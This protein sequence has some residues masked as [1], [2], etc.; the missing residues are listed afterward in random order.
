MEQKGLRHF[1]LSRFTRVIITDETW[2]HEGHHVI[3]K[4]DPFRIV[5]N[6]Q[7]FLHIRFKMGAKNELL[8]RFPLTKNHILETDDEGIYDLQC[9]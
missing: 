4:T 6:D 7:I 3:R 8:E 9:K 5:D 2:E 1:R